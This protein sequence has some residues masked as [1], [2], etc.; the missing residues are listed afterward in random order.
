[1]MTSDL[2]RAA[3]EEGRSASSKDHAV[4]GTILAVAGIAWFGWGHVGERL[5]TSLGLGMIAGL[6]L[7]VVGALLT[8][9]LPGPTRM[10]TDRRARNTYWA[11]MAGQLVAIVAGMALMNITERPE[12][13]PP[14][15]LTAVGVHF[16]P[17]ARAFR[18]RVLDV[19]GW[20]C[21]AVAALATVS[22]IVG[23]LPVPTVAGGGAGLVL[24]IAAALAFREARRG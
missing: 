17:L 20:A 2:H 18:S 15:V 8:R 13:V 21:I 11:S 19:A 14:W 24:L 3:A 22:G 6:L 10:S 12:Y 5:T 16:L 4:T 23:W 7:F 1:M 9:S